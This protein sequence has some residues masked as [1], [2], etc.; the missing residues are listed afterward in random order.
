M[1]EW[2][3]A[4]QLD[5]EHGTA[6]QFISYV[7]A[8]FP[9]LDDETMEARSEVGLVPFGLEDL[10]DIHEENSSSYDLYQ[11]EGT[12]EIEVQEFESDTPTKGGVY[13]STVDEG[14][15]LEDIAL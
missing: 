3:H 11:V 10:G 5:P 13:A 9:V 1:S 14:W 2:E 12:S 8:Q 6:K 15:F 7:R 4:L